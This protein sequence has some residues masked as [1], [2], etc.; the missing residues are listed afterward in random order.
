MI[1]PD[2]WRCRACGCLWRDNHDNTV[3]LASAKQASCADC[4]MRPTFTACEPLYRALVPLPATE[5]LTCSKQTVHPRGF[6][7]GCEHLEGHKGDHAALI[8]DIAEYQWAQRTRVPL[9]ATP[10]EE[11]RAMARGFISLWDS[12]DVQDA[13]DWMYRLRNRAELLTTV[14]FLPVQVQDSPLAA[15]PTDLEQI[16]QLIEVEERDCRQ[17]E[18][19]GKSHHARSIW[20]ACAATCGLLAGK[21]RGLSVAFLPVQDEEAKAQ[22]YELAARL[23]KRWEDAPSADDMVRLEELDDIADEVEAIAAALGASRPSPAEKK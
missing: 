13:D 21:V 9:P 18:H 3:S 20:G 5:K 2:F 8:D 4:E 11:E 12:M 6:V 1:E 14:A 15:T 19:D 22:L 16:A 17:K 23:H 7:V 10:T